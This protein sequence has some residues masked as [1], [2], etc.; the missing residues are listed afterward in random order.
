MSNHIIFYSG[1]KSSFAVADYVKN[2]IAQPNDSVVLYFTDTKWEDE[3]TYRFIYEGATKLKLPLL[4]H[5]RNMTPLELFVEKRFMG[6]NRVGICSKELKM[7]VAEDFLKKGIKPE[8]ESWYNQKCLKHNDF[9]SNA[10]LY[11]GIGIEELHREEPIKENWKPFKVVMPK[12]EHTIDNDL[13][14]KKYNIRQ[15]RLYDLNFSHGN[16]KGRSGAF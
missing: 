9:V 10:T 4:V 7:K 14:L 8:K 16:C 15:P 1:G 6:N 5:S 12:V 11:F 13:V 2:H 3:D